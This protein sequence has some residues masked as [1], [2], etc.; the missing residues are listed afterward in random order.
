[1]RSWGGSCLAGEERL[2][3][4]TGPR[5]FWGGTFTSA[6]AAPISLKKSD[7][8]LNFLQA[9][10]ASSPRFVWRER[11]RKRGGGRGGMKEFSPR[12]PIP[13]PLRNAGCVGEAN[14]GPLQLG[15]V[16][17]LKALSL[18]AWD[19]RGGHWQGHRGVRGKVEGSPDSNFE[20]ASKMTGPKRGRFLRTPDRTG[21]TKKGQI[22]T[23]RNERHRTHRTRN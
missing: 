20:A 22:I 1:M 23:L 21:H 12:F 15:W 4:E 19:C 17:S 13:R 6:Q 2:R 9:R 7:H 16:V 10:L 18:Y 11:E 8:R 5:I 3:D 14:E